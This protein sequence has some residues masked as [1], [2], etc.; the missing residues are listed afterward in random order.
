MYCEYSS[1]QNGQGSSQTVPCQYELCIPICLQHCSQ[2]LSDCIVGVRM[3]G[4]ALI[5]LF[6]P[7]TVLLKTQSFHEATMYPTHIG[8]LVP[9]DIHICSPLVRIKWL[10]TPECNNN[11]VGFGLGI[12]QYDC[13]C[14]PQLLVI[15]MPSFGFLTV[16]NGLI[17]LKKASC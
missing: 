15:C 4:P 10:C 14:G 8:Q 16:K 6:G 9:R 2:L 5:N 7:S 13:S 3:L 1:K 12:L 17:S 11:Q